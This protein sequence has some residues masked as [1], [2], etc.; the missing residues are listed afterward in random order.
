M[1]DEHKLDPRV[2]KS[3][4]ALLDAV[5]KLIERGQNPDQISITELVA[6]AGV[7]RPT[8]Y[9]HFS[10]ITELV[11]A[12]VLRRIENM[13]AAIPQERNV[14]PGAT[15]DAIRTMLTFLSE[16][17]T[18]CAT[19]F[20][21]SAAQHLLNNL[22]D[23]IAHRLQYV[24]PIGT[25]VETFTAIAP[26]KYCQFLAAGAIWLVQEWLL[27]EANPKASLEKYVEQIST[28]L[29]LGGQLKEGGNGN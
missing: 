17:G 24:S 22:V 14:D 10:T 18:Y 5:D 1:E 16:D 13:F 28:S 6:K 29:L 21:S 26:E 27:T 8:F 15:E 7:S 11:G 25:K 4:T 3:R 9:Q 23:Y 20:N 12:S 2:E 19:V